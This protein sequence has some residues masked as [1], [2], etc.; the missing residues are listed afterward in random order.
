MIHPASI[1][2]ES[3]LIFT[4]PKISHRGVLGQWAKGVLGQRGVANGVLPSHSGKK[5]YPLG[6][7]EE[8]GLFV[9]NFRK[10]AGHAALSKY[11]QGG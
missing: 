7:W 3:G 1:Y 11:T 5:R 10:P 6:R 4:P 9:G 2:P 8:H